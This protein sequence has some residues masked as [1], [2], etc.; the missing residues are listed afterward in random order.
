MKFNERYAVH[1]EDFKAC[2]TNRIRGEFLVEKVFLKDEFRLSE[3]PEI[4]RKI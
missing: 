3:T 2:D 1:P 4:F